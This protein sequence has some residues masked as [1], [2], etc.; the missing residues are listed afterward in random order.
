M[1]QGDLFIDN[2]IAYPHR[3]YPPIL[4][5]PYK[6]TQ[7]P[8][9]RC[10]EDQANYHRLLRE[11][12]WM[13]PM[14][15]SIAYDRTTLSELGI[16]IMVYDLFNKSR[17]DFDLI[18]TLPS[19]KTLVYEFIASF[20]SLGGVNTAR[21]QRGWSF[22]IQN[23]DYFWTRREVCERLDFPEDGISHI[24]TERTCMATW[25]NLTG[26]DELGEN[27]SPYL[28]NSETWRYVHRLIA[29][30]INCS[31]ETV[32]T[33]TSFD[34]D[35]LSAI[36][37]GIPVNWYECFSDRFESMQNGY[38][39]FQFVGCTSVITAIAEMCKYQFLLS[40]H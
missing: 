4:Q 30:G 1:S 13:K 34:L 2:G 10:E 12:A 11:P 26:L 33:V 15:S 16:N 9:F 31:P 37:Q 36:E 20:K 23:T 27:P 3:Q 18:F 25:K 22:R 19:Y 28:I 29:T 8:H 32:D 35:I 14:V 24:P 7:A 6:I 5:I 39:M 21:D 17:L 40:P 38:S